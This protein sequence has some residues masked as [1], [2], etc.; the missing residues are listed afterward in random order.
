MPVLSPSICRLVCTVRSSTSSTANWQALVGWRFGSGHAPT[1]VVINA[2]PATADLH[3]RLPPP[4]S[5]GASPDNEKA[6]SNTEQ[7]RQAG[8]TCRYAGSYPKDGAADVT[9]AGLAVADLG[10]LA[11]DCSG[12]GSIALPGY[13]IVAIHT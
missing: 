3:L 2:G 8:G 1:L 5:S 9:R 4:P 13:A 6:S 7:G 12:G 10:E 11:G